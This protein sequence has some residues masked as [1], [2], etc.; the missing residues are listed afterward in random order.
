MWSTHPGSRPRK[1]LDSFLYLEGK[2]ELL[3]AV[4]ILLTGPPGCGK[5][6]LVEKVIQRLRR[7]ASGFI[8]R[9]MREGK[10]RVGFSIK[11]LDGK[12]AIL[13]HR[14]RK[15]PLRV[16]PYGVCLEEF[17][18]LA[19]PSIKAAREGQVVVMDEIGKMEILSARF[20][21][22]VEEVLE[23]PWDLLATVG[24][25]KDPFLLWVRSHPSVR[26]INVTLENREGL[27]EEIL[28]ALDPA[29]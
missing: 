6:T 26:L 23:A 7:P 25:G 10:R 5:S 20:R 29:C 11:T 13:A 9:E 14:D 18:E 15:S 17:E 28:E 19:L 4:K 21:K 27:V 3:P 16:G 8:T 22:A 12:E 1:P 2:G 24:K